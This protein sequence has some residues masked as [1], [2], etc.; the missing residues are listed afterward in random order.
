MP[1]RTG[2]ACVTIKDI[3]RLSGCGV[4][5]VSRVLNNHPDVSE[6]TRRRVM[7]V[8]EA[9]NFRPNN[10][11]KH[12]KQQTTTSI[13]ILVKGSQNML[14]AGLVECIQALLRENGRD[15]TVDY[16][17]EEANEVARAA[18][19]CRER[20]PLGILFLGGDLELFREGFQ[21]VG[22]P[23]VLLTNAAG[24]LDFANLSSITTDDNAAAGQAIEYL[25]ARG[26]RHIGIISGSWSCTQ[27]GYSR[28]QGG[29]R[30]CRRLGLPFDEDRQCEPC[31]YS[32]GEAY[33]AARRLVERCPE[34]TAIFAVSDVMAIGVIRALRD[35]GKRVPEDV[36]VVGFDGIPL[37]QYFVPRLTT[38]RQDTQRLAERG[39]E[40]LLRNVEQPSRPFHELVP[41][42][43]VEGE[44]VARIAPSEH[45]D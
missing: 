31:R 39:V 12:L 4:A 38:V 40:V 32:M 2:G 14:F 11:A 27:V 18:Q 29:L 22:V 41:F 6:E 13:A 23:C 20:K 35:L 30:A 43:L 33:A 37:S 5:T 1:F 3:A 44:S 21:S 42:Q 8:V 15:A 16:L 7:E 34:L 26:H 45:R 19:L 25:A 10:N 36:S 28:F 9:N 24:E 17:D